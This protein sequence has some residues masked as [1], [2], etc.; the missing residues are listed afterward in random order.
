MTVL[1]SIAVALLIV[2]VGLAAL[3]R[4]GLRDLHD[5]PKIPDNDR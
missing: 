2:A 5:K 3:Y 1:I 4:Y